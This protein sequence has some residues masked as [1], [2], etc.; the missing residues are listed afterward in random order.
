MTDGVVQTTWD[1]M[2]MQWPKAPHVD[3]GGQEL[4][5]CLILASNT[6]NFWKPSAPGSLGKNCNKYTSKAFIFSWRI[7][8]C[9]CWCVWI[10]LQKCKRFFFRKTDLKKKFLSMQKSLS[11]RY[12]NKQGNIDSVAC[13]WRSINPQ[14][15]SLAWHWYHRTLVNYGALPR[16]ALFRSWAQITCLDLNTI[17]YHSHTNSLSALYYAMNQ[18]TASA[19]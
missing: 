9:F 7:D 13:A 16:F 3:G 4:P 18:D 2:K 10:H 5:L 14:C 12:S 15:S 8:F 6:T 17:M 19:S 11:T 1:G